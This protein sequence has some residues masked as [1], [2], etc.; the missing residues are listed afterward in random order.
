MTT[1]TV[2]SWLLCV[3][4][5]LALYA[6]VITVIDITRAYKS[7]KLIKAAEEEEEEYWRHP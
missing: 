5:A 1:I 6:I 3:T 4:I 7:S 2:P